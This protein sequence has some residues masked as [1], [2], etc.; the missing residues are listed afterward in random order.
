MSPPEPLRLFTLTFA[1][2]I[3]AL[4]LL[5]AL[6]GAV[7]HGGRTGQVGCAAGCECKEARP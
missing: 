5:A 6:A 7:L 3:T 4:A 2:C 1:W